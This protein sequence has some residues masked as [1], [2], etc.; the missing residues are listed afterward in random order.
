MSLINAH[1]CFV[2]LVDELV[3]RVEIKYDPKQD[4]WEIYI[5]GEY[6]SASLTEDKAMSLSIRL[7]ELGV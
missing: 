6:V 1:S 3:S 5:D 2:S 7:I 4:L